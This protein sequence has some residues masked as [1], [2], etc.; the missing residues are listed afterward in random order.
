M[1]DLD[2]PFMAKQIYSRIFQNGALDL[3]AVPQAVDDAVRQLRESGVPAS[4]W[5]TYVHF[6]I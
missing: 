5:A 4:R 3:G 6:G 2:G 1:N